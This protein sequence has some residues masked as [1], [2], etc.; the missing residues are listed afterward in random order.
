[1]QDALL[2]IVSLFLAFRATQAGR[3]GVLFSM[4]GARLWFLRRPWISQEAGRECA[5]IS[6]LVASTILLARPLLWYTRVGRH[7]ITFHSQDL[8]D[9]GREA[10]S[11][12]YADIDRDVP[13]E[14]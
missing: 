13:G 9:F 2:A 7:L 1:M 12:S 8:K 4:A 11:V 3:Y 10:G 6:V 14:G 5:G